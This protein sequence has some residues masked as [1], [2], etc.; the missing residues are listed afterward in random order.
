M[1]GPEL[2]SASPTF[3]HVVSRLRAA[4]CVF[5]EDEARLLL[6]EASGPAELSEWVARRVTGVPLE[7]ILGWAE[8]CGLRMAVEPGVFVPRRRTELLVSEA[9]TLLRGSLATASCTTTD[10]SSPGVV[11]DL[12]CGSGAVGVGIA[13]GV[14]GA[15][16]HSADI[17]PVAVSCGRANVAGV[18]G[19]I[20]QGD[21]YS[22]LPA[23]LRGRVRLLAVNAPYVPTGALRTMPPEARNYEP[24]VSLDGG[25][26]GLDLHRR[27]I[28]EAAEWLAPNGHLLIESS[29]RQAAGTSTLMV[30]SGMPARTVHSEEL[31]GTVV[32]GVAAGGRTVRAV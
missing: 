31:D 18:G 7:Y 14:P 10:A 20:H 6:S 26:D 27:V 28:A 30:A 1:P 2:L 12:C 16:L 32:I 3:A 21:L 29:K 19:Q 5:A 11:V 8:F 25:A 4:G 15:E 23:G 9:V 22:A 24:R 13:S 17:D